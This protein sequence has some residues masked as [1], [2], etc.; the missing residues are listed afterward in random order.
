MNI[1]DF[2][3]SKMNTYSEKFLSFVLTEANK[4]YYCNDK[5]IMSDGEYDMLK[6]FIESTYPNNKAIKEGQHFLQCCY[7]KK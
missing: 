4:G 3:I 2:D 7:T 1:N 5:P 6:E